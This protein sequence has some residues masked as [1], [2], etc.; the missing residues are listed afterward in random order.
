MFPWVLACA[1]FC[2]AYLSLGGLTITLDIP[3]WKVVG[4]RT[5]GGGELSLRSLNV[6]VPCQVCGLL[7]LFLTA[8]YSDTVVAS[9]FITPFHV[10]SYIF[11]ILFF[12]YLTNSN[13]LEFLRVRL[14]VAMAPLDFSFR[15][16]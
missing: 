8:Y 16:I 3:S 11:I 13:H 7:S 12:P 6:S 4:L 10:T 2:C 5:E 15:E 9:C 1:H 14:P